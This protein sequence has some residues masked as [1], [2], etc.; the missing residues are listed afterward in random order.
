LGIQCI[1]T[2]TKGTGI[3]CSGAASVHLS[4]SRVLGNAG[5]AVSLQDSC[6]FQRSDDCVFR[7]NSGGEIKDSRVKIIF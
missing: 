5:P 4:R 1:I 2:N 6:T 3:E 7:D